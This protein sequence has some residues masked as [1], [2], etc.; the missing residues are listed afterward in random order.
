MKTEIM[1]ALYRY[2]K[3]DF[4]EENQLKQIQMLRTILEINQDVVRKGISQIEDH[5]P[6]IISFPMLGKGL[7]LVRE[8][9]EPQVIETILIN[10]AFA[11]DVDLLESLLVLEGVSSIQMLRA[12][13]V[14]K[15]LLLSYF[16]FSM[17][18][19]LRRNLL[20]L[21]LDFSQPLNK[22]ELSEILKGIKKGKSWFEETKPDS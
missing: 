2:L 14:T 15:E 22:N 9:Q 1:L 17:Q 4:S 8:G 6:D 18:D 5:E 19:H 3:K 16:S 10:T 13:D 11:N 7:K 12:A 20:D 21:Q